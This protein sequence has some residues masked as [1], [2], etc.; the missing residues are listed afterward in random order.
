MEMSGIGL[1]C[2]GLGFADGPPTEERQAMT[3]IRAA[4][5]RSVILF[6]TP[7]KPTVPPPMKNCLGKRS[8]SGHHR[9]QVRL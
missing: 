4:F 2:M 5:V 8:F 9:H 1:G 6:L 3:L 7:P